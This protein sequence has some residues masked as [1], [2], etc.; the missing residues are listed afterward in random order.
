LWPNDDGHKPELK[1]EVNKDVGVHYQ[2]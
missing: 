1:T 2:E